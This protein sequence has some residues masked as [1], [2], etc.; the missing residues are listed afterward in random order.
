MPRQI[1]LTLHRWDRSNDPAAGDTPRFE[2]LNADLLS[3]IEVVRGPQSALWGSE[4]VGGVVAVNGLPAPRS[5]YS[6]NLEGGSFGFR[7]AGISASVATDDANLSAAVGMQRAT[8]IDSFDGFGDKDGYRNVS[9]RVR[10]TWQVAPDIELGVTA[11]NLASHN[12][13]DGA[14]A[15]TFVRAD[16]LD[17]SKSRMSAGRVWA[18]VGHVTNPWTA[19]VSASTLSSLNRNF[20]VSAELNRTKGARSVVSAQVERRMQHGLHRAHVDRRGGC[21]A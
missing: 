1:T 18:Q 8:G 15:F 20:L 21:G 11:F 13:F 5:G 6:A 3:R 16:T 14:D 10:A 17:N 9:G 2:L 7:R 12:D 19:T 4:A